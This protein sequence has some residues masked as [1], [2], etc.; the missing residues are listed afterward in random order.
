MP[1]TDKHQGPADD[2]GA[3]LENLLELGLDCQCAAGPCWHSFACRPSPDP[4]A[5]TDGCGAGSNSSFQCRLW[6]GAIEGGIPI[7]A[8]GAFCTS[9]SRA[10]AVQHRHGN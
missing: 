9:Y 8:G 3:P 6:S 2:S 1:G 4:P 10:T 5:W 7:W